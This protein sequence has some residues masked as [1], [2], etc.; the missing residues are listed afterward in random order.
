[1]RKDNAVLHHWRRAT[2]ENREYPF[3]K[4]N[5]IMPVPDYSDSEYGSFLSREG[6]TKRQTDYLF[7]LCRRFDLRFTVIHDRWEKD[8]YGQKTMEDLKERYYEVAGLLIKNR[9]EPS[10]PEPKVFTYDAE[11]ERKRKEQLDR[12]WKRT[13]EQ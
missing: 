8:I 3:A 6:W 4:F 12:L 13:P 5:K 1:A 2:D 11:S 7:D 9:A 10:M